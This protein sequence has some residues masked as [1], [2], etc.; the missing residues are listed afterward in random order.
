M[1]TAL[2][3]NVPAPLATEA[4]FDTMASSTGFRRIQLFGSSSKEVKSEQVPVGVFG[5]V[6]GQEIKVLGK[7]FDC[8][9][10]DWR[11]KAM[12][13]EPVMEIS[14]DVKSDA[15]KAM[16]A[17]AQV[18][19]SNCMCGIEYL[20]Y[21]PKDGFVPYYLGN[22]S[23]MYIAKAMK[24]LIGKVATLKVIYMKDADFP[25]HAPNA[26]A[27]AVP[28]ENLHSQDAINKEIAAFRTPQ[29]KMA[30][31]AVVKDEAPRAR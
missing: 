15:F 17:E 30:E 31:M 13:T 6:D 16:Q 19:N 9:V 5:L 23:S 3:I 10:L 11:P 18:K 2:A 22:K 28:M 21:L 8:L 14:Y 26:T 29:A 12:R 4:D 25:Y 27:C 7:T 24:A 20:L 1:E